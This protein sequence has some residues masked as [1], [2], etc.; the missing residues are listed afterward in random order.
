M[1]RS[2]MLV[3]SSALVVSSCG[4]AESAPTPEVRAAKAAQAPASKLA[5]LVVTPSGFRSPAGR[6][7]RETSGPL[8]SQTFVDQH[9]TSPYRDRALLLNADFTEGYYANRVS[10]DGRTTARTYLFRAGTPAK[11]RVLQQGFWADSN[12][13]TPLRV[14]GVPGVQTGTKVEV[15]AANGRTYAVLET[16]FSVGRTVVQVLVRRRLTEGEQSLAPNTHPAVTLTQDQYRRLAKAATA[17]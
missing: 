12:H 4:G 13:G 3:L 11:A 14:P 17:Q 2:S 5:A 15:S 16:T 1:L 8:D 10:A 6:T 9:S 7:A